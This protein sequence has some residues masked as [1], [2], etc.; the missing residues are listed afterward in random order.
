MTPCRFSPI[1]FWLLRSCK[2]FSL[3]HLQ[4]LVSLEFIFIGHCV[5]SLNKT[6]VVYPRFSSQLLPQLSHYQRKI[7]HQAYILDIFLLHDLKKSKSPATVKQN[8]FTKVAHQ[9]LLLTIRLSNTY[10]RTKTTNRRIWTSI[11]KRS[12]IAK[13]FTVLIKHRSENIQKLKK[14]FNEKAYLFSEEK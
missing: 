6:G 1:L 14:V 3:K 8:S 12:Y 9:T 4:S 13:R 11:L 2:R 7:T 5:F 10:Y